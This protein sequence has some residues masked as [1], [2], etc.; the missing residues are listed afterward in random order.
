MMNL[1]QNQV[2][3]LDCTLRDGGYY[4]DWDFDDNLVTEY[5]ETMNRLPIDFIEIGY[6]SK[7]KEEYAG[8]FYYLPEFVLKT[9]KSKT[10]KKLAI[11]LNEKEV[12]PDDLDVLLNPCKGLVSMVRL[13][14]APKNYKRALKLSKKVKELGFVVSF[15][16][17]YASRWETDFKLDESLEELNTASDYFYV[18][19]S[20]G[21]LYP[22]QVS[23]IF[24]KLKQHLNIPLG[25]HGHNNLEMA[26]VNSLAALNSGAGIIDSTICGMGRGAGNLKTELWFSIMHQQYGIPVDFDALNVLTNSFLILNDKY[27][28]GTNLPYMVSGAFSLPQN[29]VMSQVKKRYY[30]LNAIIEDVGQTITSEITETNFPKFENFKLADKV[31]LVGGGNSAV[32]FSSALIEFL[33]KNPE[34]CIIYASSKNVP[35]FSGLPNLQIHCLSGR[36]GKRLEKLFKFEELNNRLFVVP[37]KNISANNYVP[38]SC[39]ENTFLLEEID[40]IDTFKISATAMATQIAVQLMAKEIFLTGY[41]G[42]GEAVTKDQL[43]LFD[44][45]QFIF[46]HLKD[47]QPE[48]VAL[49]PTLYSIPLKSIFSLI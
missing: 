43:E 11:I 32:K 42:Y 20:Y 44:E 12:L 15:N 37:P 16:L 9:I 30:S 24:K 39:L 45:N 26:L 49:T 23:D 22:E 35:V 2:S 36:E 6:R 31:L 19:D 13:A 25:F 4:T 1:G 46:N 5:F 10:D 8:A 18:V 41:D 21:G 14:V 48:L 7:L 3:L 17:M 40:F 47:D 34:I 33:K 28:W 29:T 27:K 38:G